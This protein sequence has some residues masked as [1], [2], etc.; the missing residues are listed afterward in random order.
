MQTSTIERA[1]RYLAH[2]HSISGSGGHAAAYAAAVALVRG[3]DLPPDEAL[4]PFREWNQTN[5]SPP[6]SESDLRHKINEATKAD[7][8]AGY[9]LANDRHPTRPPSAS[10]P[11]H[12][13]TPP[14]QDEAA[15]KAA[16]RQQWPS[17]RLG[18]DKELHA[19]AHLRGI[20]A[21]IAW[22]A[23]KEGILRFS[24]SRA[25]EPCFILT[26]GTLAQVRRMDGQP[27]TKQ[28]G[29][30]MKAQCLPGSAGKWLGRAMLERSPSAPALIAEG[31]VAWL[32][33]AHAITSTT[34]EGLRAW[35]PF[36]A[37]SANV[38]LEARELALLANRRVL[39]ARDRGSEGAAAAVSWQAALSEAGINAPIWTP[40]LPAKDLGEAMRLPDFNPDSIFQ[41]PT[42]PIKFSHD[43]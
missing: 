27:F 16:Q 42:Q 41:T 29:S 22:I 40:P 13:P 43:N 39:I 11:F 3:Y 9:L 15:K 8:P 28:D 20:E 21:G 19:V 24:T 37:L 38:K 31:L 35:L 26:E 36:A 6:W 33:A 14:P 32:E 18:T 30:T 5:A 34:G 23:Q 7:R 12:R 25:G 4:A 2:I 17:F 1:Q 10:K